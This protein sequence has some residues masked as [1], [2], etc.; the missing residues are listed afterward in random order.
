VED[1][2][3]V[4][5]LR[6]DP[7][8]G[9]WVIIAGERSLRPN[10]LRHY[11]SRVEDQDPCPFCAGREGMTPPEVLAYRPDGGANSPSWSVRVVPNRFPALRIEGELDKQGEGLYDLMRGI[12][13]HEVVIETPEHGLDPSRYPA[14]QMEDVL[15][16]YRDRMTDLLR[17]SRFRYVLVFKNHGP[18][19]G[20]TLPHPHSQIIALPIVPARIEAELGGAGAYYQYRGRCIYCDILAQEL[21]DAR[22]LVAQNAD[23]VAFAPFA[24]RF[25]FEILI[26]PR[27]HDAFFW[28]ITRHQ[29]ERL[30]EVLQDVLRRYRLALEDPPYNFIVHTAPPA[31]PHPERFHWQVE[32]IPKLTEVAGF[33]WGSGFYINPTPP[34]EAARHLRDLERVMDVPPGHLLPSRPPGEGEA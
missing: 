9:R 29:V 18:A 17:D 30:A 28:T 22:R 10:P 4:S 20:A 16:A 24:S 6:K 5:E 34:E 26:L 13:A 21:A 23:F 32:V 8:T 25:P 33:E 15:H 7:V 1:A 11:A 19:A 3:R 31:D 14:R 12:G 27:H 2:R